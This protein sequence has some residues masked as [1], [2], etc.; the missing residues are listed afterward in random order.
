MWRC[1]L[2]VAE[3]LAMIPSD[4]VTGSDLPAHV[5]VRR[6]KGHKR[7]RV[8]I[9]PEAIAVVEVWLAAR[10]QLPELPHRANL[11][12]TITKGHVGKPLQRPALT[13]KVKESAA[14]AGIDRRVH[15]HGFRHTCAVNLLREG[16]DVKKIQQFLGHSEL[17][18]TARYLDHQLPVE[19]LELGAAREWPT[20][21]PVA[22]PED[23]I[24]VLSRQVA[25]LSG[26]LQKLT[27]A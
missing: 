22:V 18:T 7:R 10:A 11:L 25:E 16:W 20:F 15:L 3:V 27:A 2:R 17:G 21:G 4:L 6:G 1:G 23:P 5:H 26:Q 13:D 19:L 8:P 12:C 14:R 24:A 9:D